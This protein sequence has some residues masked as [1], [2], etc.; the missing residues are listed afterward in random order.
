M[1]EMEHIF[2]SSKLC[3]LLLVL[4]LHYLLVDLSLFEAK[5]GAESSRRNENQWHVSVMSLP[6]RIYVWYV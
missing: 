5:R 6:C 3:R 2:K 1:Q 4:P